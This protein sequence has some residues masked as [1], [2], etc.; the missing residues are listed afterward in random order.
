MGLDPGALPKRKPWPP[1]AD[2]VCDGVT[3]NQKCGCEMHGFATA[4]PGLKCRDLCRDLCREGGFFFLFFPPPISD[5]AKVPLLGCFRF[6]FNSEVVFPLKPAAGL[7]IGNLK[8]T[9]TPPR[10]GGGTVST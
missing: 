8:W 1:L 3:Q 7:S 2:G 10:Q 6:Q 4:A 5:A 9:S